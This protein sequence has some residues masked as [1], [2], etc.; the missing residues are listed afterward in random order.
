MQYKFRLRG[1]FRRM[2][3]AHLP[4]GEPSESRQAKISCEVHSTN[5]TG[6]IS[7]EGLLTI[8]EGTLFGFSTLL[9]IFYYI[10]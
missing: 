4:R 6:S 2:S 3:F 1:Y 10:T 8:D 7:F 5:E 9:N